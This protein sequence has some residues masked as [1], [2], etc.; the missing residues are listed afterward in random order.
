V[1]EEVYAERLSLARHVAG[2]CGRP[3]R[4]DPASKIL[5]PPAF[6]ATGTGAPP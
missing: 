4:W 5:R 6:P 1:P 2:L 3:L